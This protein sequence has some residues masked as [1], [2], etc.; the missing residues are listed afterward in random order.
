MV[1]GLRGRLGSPQEPSVLLCQ[2]LHSGF[3]PTW[4]SWL[5]WELWEGN[6]G[7]TLLKSGMLLTWPRQGTRDN[8]SSPDSLGT[9]STCITAWVERDHCYQPGIGQGTNLL[10]IKGT[11]LLGIKDSHLLPPETA[12]LGGPLSC[13]G[14]QWAPRSSPW[15]WSLL[16]LAKPQ[17]CSTEKTPWSLGWC[18][19]LLET[20]PSPTEKGKG[21]CPVPGEFLTGPF[22]HIDRDVNSSGPVCVHE[23]WLGYECCYLESIFQSLL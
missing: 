2:T 3:T 21:V 5:Y 4:L 18:P 7:V 10:G 19:P 15:S 9:L 13:P 1:S 20:N 8:H 16:E 6:V 12:V 23:E 14:L 11:N 17:G 22:A